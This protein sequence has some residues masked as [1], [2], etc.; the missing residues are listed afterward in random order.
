MFENSKGLIF[1]RASARRGSLKDSETHTAKSFG[2][3]GITAWGFR[4]YWCM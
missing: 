3:S 1:A 4:K 2:N